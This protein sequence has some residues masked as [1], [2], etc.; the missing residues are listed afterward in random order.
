M[1][2]RKRGWALA[3]GAYIDD[4]AA[5]EDARPSAPNPTAAAVASLSS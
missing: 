4:S 5:D 3:H 1:H 2:L